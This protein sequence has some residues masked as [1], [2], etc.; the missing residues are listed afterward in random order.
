M[1]RSIAPALLLPAL[2]LGVGVA[3]RDCTLL[4]IAAVVG[5]RLFLWRMDRGAPWQEWRAAVRCLWAGLA[6]MAAAAALVVFVSGGLL[7]L[8]AMRHDPQGPAL[9]LMA[10][11]TLLFGAVWLPGPRRREETLFWAALFSVA[12]LVTAPDGAGIGFWP[13]AFT[14]LVAAGLGTAGWRLARHTSRELLQSGQRR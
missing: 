4:A 6:G 9:A 1:N 13:C 5:H 3:W 11:G 12:A 14:L 2:L 7:G 8:W 10:V